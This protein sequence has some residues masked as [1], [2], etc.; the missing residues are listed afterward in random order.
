MTNENNENAKIRSDL[1]V[2]SRESGVDSSVD[3]KADS[4]ESIPKLSLS[5][6][7]ARE[8]IPQNNKGQ[9]M[10][11][12]KQLKMLV[13]CV[14][15]DTG[16]LISL[17][18]IDTGKV[19]NMKALFYKSARS[20]FDGIEDWNVSNVVGF[21]L[22]FA[23]CKTFNA[24]IEQWGDKIKN[25]RTFE[26]MFWGAESF[27]R[28]I[29]A[30]WDTSSAT[31]MIRM[32][33][34]A[35]SFNNGGEPFGE[36]WKMD[37]VG[38]TWEM[39][40][41]AERFNQPINHWIMSSVTKCFT[42]FMGAKAFNQPLDKWDLSNAVNL[43]SMFNKAESFNQD[44]SSWGTRLGKAQN[45]KRMFA[46]TKSLT[47]DFLGAWKIPENC[48]TD[49]ITK[50]SALES[51]DKSEI[52][53]ITTGNAIKEN[54]FDK[55]EISQIQI[56]KDILALH[57]K[58]NKEFVGEWI[59][60]NILENDYKVF[61]AKIKGKGEDDDENAGEEKFS[62]DDLE[63]GDYNKW[64]FA[65]YRVFDCWFL[66]EKDNKKLNEIKK[67]S[68]FT[69]EQYTDMEAT[70][71]DENDKVKAQKYDNNLEILFDSKEISILAKNTAKQKN[72]LAVLNAYMLA[73]AYNTEMQELGTIAR[74]A[75]EQRRKN[76]ANKGRFSWLPY[77]FS[78]TKRTN[79]RLYKSLKDS[80]EF[81]CNF[82]LHSYHNIPIAQNKLDDTSL[83]EIW[84]QMS[85]TYMIQNRHDELKETIMQVT[86]L[87]SDE[88][89]ESL[90]LI[91]RWVAILSAI[92][93]FFAAV[94]VI[95][96]LCLW[97]ASKF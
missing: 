88:R 64:D 22:C 62:L 41:N 68:N 74:K 76:K 93:A 28:P 18:R 43:G 84:Q 38:W 12:K 83:V 39:F 13:N 11:D 90:N 95:K 65:F 54:V 9:F 96:D 79:K 71:W 58:E 85:K 63:Q 4:P 60:Q 72:V 35:K 47:I 80:Y 87:V 6:F 27:D 81:V 3:S 32:F 50:G 69:I 16:K 10:P 21:E 48:N 24:K 53:V 31:N 66:I 40:W 30:H 57:L 7:L 77:P 37:K 42:M 70:D 73:K 34:Q 52:K 94:P 89:Q 75:N 56:S 14:D 29:G 51:K 5:E 44:L 25:A 78:N 15:D 26:A 8:F 49:N 23:Q 33:S 61:L 46:D 91:M 67:W 2:D 36:K 17:K 97:I 19:T 82:D 59:P 55:C 86:Q 1:S 45:M 92:A 20:D